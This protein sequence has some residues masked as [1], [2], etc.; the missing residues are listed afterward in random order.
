MTLSLIA[1]AL[2]T[3]GVTP[4]LATAQS[5][6][7][8]P[9]SKSSATSMSTRHIPAHAP[10]SHAVLTSRHAAEDRSG[11]WISPAPGRITSGFGGR[12]GS[13]HKGVDIANTIGTPVLAAASGKVIAAGPAR[14]FGMWVK[15]AH[16][17]NVVSVYGHINTALVHQGQ[18]VSVGQKI[19]TIGKRGNATGPHLHFQIEVNGVPVDPLGFYRERHIRLP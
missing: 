5:T 8:S 19:A 17:G 6:R 7:H 13:V 1:F 18:T 9:A 4:G 3:T 16:P 10:F 14:G 2:A 12:W 15:I 11:R